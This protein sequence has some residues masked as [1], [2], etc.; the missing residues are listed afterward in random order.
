MSIAPLGGTL[1]SN[2]R[3][4]PD[5]VRAYLGPDATADLRRYFDRDAKRPFTGGSFEL[6]A[7]G[8]D[9]PEVASRFTSDDIVAVSMLSVRIPGSAALAIL[10]THAE[11]LNDLLAPIP[12]DIDLWDDAA[13]D[14]VATVSSA[15]KLWTRLEAL[16]GS[17]WVTAGKLL[18]RK[19]PRLIPVY[20]RVV[21]A[22]F[23]LE[24]GGSWW[25]SLQSVLRAEPSL[26][27]KAVALRKESGINESITVL[28]VIDV[29]VWMKDQGSAPP[30]IGEDELG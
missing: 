3:I 9:R 14:Q 15:D 29:A 7:G 21:Q 24:R 11:E 8:G 28:R 1:V 5:Q 20:D 27:D 25:T 16:E 30:V 4:E 23:G 17:G 13:I 10:D 19:R 18:A 12:V 6:F 2:V 22:A 26:V